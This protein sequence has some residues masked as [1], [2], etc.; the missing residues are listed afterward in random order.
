MVCINTWP[1]IFVPL[2]NVSNDHQTYNAKVLENIGSAS[3][4]ANSELTGEKL[5]ERINGMIKDMSK[6]KS[7]RLQLCGFWLCFIELNCVF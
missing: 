2:P 6:L 3:I 7:A 1:A 5:D 4:I